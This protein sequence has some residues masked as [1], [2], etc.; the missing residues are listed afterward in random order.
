MVDRLFGEAAESLHD[1]VGTRKVDWDADPPSPT[2]ISMIAAVVS[3]TCKEE[4]V[5]ALIA[6]E[7]KYG[8]VDTDNHC[9]KRTLEQLGRDKYYECNQQAHEYFTCSGN[10]ENCLQKRIDFI[11]CTATHYVLER[12][13]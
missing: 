8:T 12:M 13:E 10:K 6:H 7:E 5:D 2:E 3:V 1:F 11:H 4:D 9:W